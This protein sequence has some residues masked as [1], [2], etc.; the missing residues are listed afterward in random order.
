MKQRKLGNSGLE[1]SA[2]GLGCMGMSHGYGNKVDDQE[3]VKLIHQAVERGINFFD[4]AE[5]Y[6]PFINEELVGKA[7][8]P[9]RD[10]I[11]VA[12]KFG[13]QFD[14]ATKE[15]QGFNSRPEHIRE[16][17]EAMLKRMNTDHID[18]L[19]QHRIDPNVPIEDVAGAVKDLI[20][21]GKVR[22][23]GLSEAD[24]L[25][26][27][28][29]H[30]VQPVTA[31]QSAYSLW[32]RAPEITVLPTLEELGIGFVPYGPL[33]HGFLTG[34]IDANTK[35]AGNDIRN[36]IPRFSEESRKAN[37]QL[38]NLLTVFAQQKNVTAA[39]LAL[40]WVLHQKP[41]MVPIPGTTKLHRLDEN[42]GAVEIELSA[43]ELVEIEGIL[44]SMKGA[45]E[46]FA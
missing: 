31:L 11:V 9:M 33:G 5:M 28:K 36:R 40:A 17:C 37:E 25:N 14:P 27:R 32:D 30:A 16:V 44:T 41:W 21:E 1:V 10:K 3:M 7:L 20:S 26:V 18:L 43:A 4:T 22:Y 45:G 23:F 6:G 46:R 34:T 24:A 15:N 35:F 42:I 19:Y 12:T 39:Q 2:I 38:I 13:F 29:A 8:A